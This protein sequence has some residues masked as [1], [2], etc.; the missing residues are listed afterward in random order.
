MGINRFEKIGRIQEPDLEITDPGFCFASD[1]AKVCDFYVPPD[2]I[3][4][5]SLMPPS[6]LVGEG[7]W[8][9]IRWAQQ[10]LFK[11]RA[12]EEAKEIIAKVEL[13]PQSPDSAIRYFFD[14]DLPALIQVSQ[15]HPALVQKMLSEK[16]ENSSMRQLSEPWYRL[17]QVAC[18]DAEAILPAL[19]GLC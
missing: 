3:N 2:V 5:T 10:L 1:E 12:L 4:R 13:L 19:D 7:G 9:P 17:V 11:R 8:N 14:N 15:K 18:G 6:P 16:L